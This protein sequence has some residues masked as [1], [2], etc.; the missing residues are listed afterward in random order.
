MKCDICGHSKHVGR[1]NVPVTEAIRDDVGYFAPPTG[2]SRTL[3]VGTC[4]C[5]LVDELSK[6][7]NDGIVQK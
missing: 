3:I 5:G 6:D 1:C 2:L 4:L 7:F